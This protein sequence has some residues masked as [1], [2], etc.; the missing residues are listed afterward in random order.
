M[1]YG[2]SKVQ[3]ISLACS[4]DKCDGFEDI[5]VQKIS[6]LVF[7]CAYMPKVPL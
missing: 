5:S 1:K 4:L 6:E 7:V 3:N 2:S